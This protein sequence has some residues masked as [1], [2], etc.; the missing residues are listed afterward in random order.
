MD[1][2]APAVTSTKPLGVRAITAADL[3]WALREGW[4]DFREKRGDLLLVPL[5]YPIVGFIASAFA[6]NAQLF[7]L[8]FPL[9]AGLSILGPAVAAGFYEIARRREAGEPSG[10][11]HFLDP[12]K[13]RARMPLLVLTVMLAG[14]FVGWLVAAWLIYGATLGRL[15]PATPSDFLAALGTPEGLTM[16]VVGNL[17]GAVFAV[18]TLAV[19]AVSF[20][21]VVDRDVDALAAVQTS[22]AAIAKNPATMARWGLTVALV[23]AAGALPLFIGLAVALPVLGYA[24]WHLYTRVVAR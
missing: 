13:G 12:L 1:D 24:T 19:S 22:V 16:I 23:L 14:L 6:W 10:W 7:P 3:D 21:L 8:V 18:A 9:V 15:G 4:A 17:V 20:P 2:T 11:T 5:I